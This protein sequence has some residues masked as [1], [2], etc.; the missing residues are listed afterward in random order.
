MPISTDTVTAQLKSS[1]GEAILS[2]EM[3]Y[4][5]LTVTVTKAEIFNVIKFLK[6][7]PAINCHFL[8]TCC[9]MHFPDNKEQFGMVYQLHNMPENFRIRLKTF[10]ADAEPVF[11]SLT[12]LW[13]A[14]NWMEREAFD[15]FG[16]RFT[17][18]PDL[19]RILNMDSLVG[20]P[21][22]KEF[23]LEDPFRYDKDD[24]MFGR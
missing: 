9:G 17:G 4:D 12:P 14:A 23:P 22:R 13:P 7:D 6:E 1:F 11:P 18:H 21:M 16:F 24:K 2:A 8:T 19:R 15:F 3:L 5:F 10:T 20:S